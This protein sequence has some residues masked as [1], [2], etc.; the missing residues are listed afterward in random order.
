MRV[1][2]SGVFF[3]GNFHN[4]PARIVVNDLRNRRNHLTFFHQTALYPYPLIQRTHK[5]WSRDWPDDT[6]ATD[7]IQVL[8]QVPIPARTSSAREK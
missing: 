8:M 4:R 6:T 7:E 5:E 2:F 3:V 1:M